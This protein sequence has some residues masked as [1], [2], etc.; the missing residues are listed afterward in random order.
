MT[1]TH[2]MLSLKRSLCAVAVIGALQFS[3]VQAMQFE[4][5]DLEV[6]LDTTVSYGVSWRVEERDDRFVGK[7]NYYNF[8]FTTGQP[9]FNPVNGGYSTNGDDG[10]L[11]T[12]KGD[13][14]SNVF[15]ITPELMLK[16]RNY[17]AF[18][19]ASMFYDF[20]LKDNDREFK[21]LNDEAEDEVGSDITLLDAYLFADWELGSRFLTVKLGNQVINWGESLF[22]QHGIS[23]INPLDVSKLRKP[24]AELKEGFIPLGALWAAMDITSDMSVE[25]FYQYEWEHT[26]LDAPGTYFSNN[27]FV[28]TGGSTV[29]L[30]FALPAESN[31]LYNARRIEDR[32]ADDNGQFG[33]KLGYFAEALND[34]EFALYYVNYHNRR[35]VISAYAHNGVR[36]NGFLEYLE[37]IEML[38]MS[39]NTNVAGLS[40]AGEVSYRKD[41]PLQV[42]DVELLFATLETAGAVPAG[43]SQ[44]T[45]TEYNPARPVLRPGDEISG[46]RLFDTWQ[47]QTVLTH[48]FG[49]NLGANQIIGLAEIGM[50]HIS[51]MPSSDEL[52]LE[53][54]GTERSGNA[55]RTE[56][57]G[58]EEDG[59][60]T[61]TS[62]GYRA[63]VKLV[64]NDVF[65]GINVSPRFI[66]QHDVNG[67]TPAP[68]Y[69]FLEGRKV[70]AL[71]VTFDYQAFL[72]ADLVYN[73]FTGAGTA[74]TLS[75]R[76][77]VSL[78]FK[79]SF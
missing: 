17:G 75:D 20:E 63:L 43:T 52:R 11:N 61:A 30:G 46:Y 15:K 48:T 21:Q 71:G 60:G 64:Y 57:E 1:E 58:V 19:R 73:R 44:L 41:E 4:A 79:Y 9:S 13:I 68:I 35:P 22:I 67:T 5:G 38:G 6:T 18:V 27:D 10:N 32:N 33:I 28:G 12:D 31:E 74:N 23:E 78:N 76:D 66:W 77:F 7:S 50:T 8:D 47:A 51:G 70:A 45:S 72:S 14:F 36:V 34:T 39:F 26:K 40:V 53:A 29:H 65:Y 16:Y 54:P 2:S 55:A 42:D 59:F 69:N 56:F 62:W 25:A 24:G 37:D 49:P 3:S